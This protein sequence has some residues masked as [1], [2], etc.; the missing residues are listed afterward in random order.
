MRKIKMKVIPEL[1]PGIRSVLETVPGIA[2]IMGSGDTTYLCGASGCS[3]VFADHVNAERMKQA[4]NAVFHCPECG[5][6]SEIDSY[7]L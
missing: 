6:Y 7:Q 5:A 3:A 1:A 4:F 2:A